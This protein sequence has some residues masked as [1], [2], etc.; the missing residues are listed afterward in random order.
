M[1]FG[2]EASREAQG[3]N[4]FTYSLVGLDSR[5]VPRIEDSLRK[6]KLELEP[7]RSPNNWSFHMKN[8][9][10]GSSRKKHAVFCNWDFDKVCFAIRSLFQ[11]I[12]SYSEHL[13]MYNIV[14]TAKGSMK[15]F[16]SKSTLERTRDNAYILLIMHIIH[17]L[18]QAGAQPV[19]QF[20]A[21]KDT[22]ANYVIQRWA[23][24]AF[25]GSQCCLIYPF[26]AKGIEIP[27]P[28]FVKPAS[29]ACLELAD[30]IS[31][32]IARLYFKKWRGQEIEEVLNPINLGKV[33][34]LGFE[35][36]LGFE[37]GKDL[38]FKR[39]ESYP[40]KLFYGS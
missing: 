39:T 20:D 8:I 3:N 14:V 4:M 11:L 32:I 9:W 35:T 31:Y 1:L 21:E 13:F 2:D 19:L 36:H 25:S 26:L 23:S 6:L 37:K 5:L 27:E 29:H 18:T 30:L 10:S 24:D 40:W 34:Y 15:G 7:S 22:K 16:K 28:K 33:T 17:E 12:Q 38:L